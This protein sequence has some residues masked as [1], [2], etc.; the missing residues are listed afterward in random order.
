MTVQLLI[1]IA[2]GVALVV[3][4]GAR[5]LRWRPFDRARVWRMPAILAIVGLISLSTSAKGLSVGPIDVT[6]IAVEL[7]F[8]VV[9]GLI[10]GRI[11]VFRRAA[12]P[13]DE[14][15]VLESRSG[16]LGMTLW[17]ALIAVR[18]GIDVAGSALGAHLLTATG[19]I[20]LTIAANRAA[21]ALVLDSRMPRAVTA[22][23]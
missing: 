18:I 5:Q 8:A 15:N 19:V 23:A 14:G 17:I 10:M 21:S 20:L 16:G 4:I 1:N 13:D 6:L 12:A 9:L 2:V 11:T 7:A 3:Y 22:T